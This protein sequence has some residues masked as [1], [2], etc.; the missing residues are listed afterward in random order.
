MANTSKYKGGSKL[1]TFRLPT[2]NYHEVRE[3][4]NELL[5]GYEIG[6]EQA[7]QEAPKL[8]KKASIKPI[9]NKQGTNTYECGCTIDNGLLKRV[10]G[11]KKGKNEH[12]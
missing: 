1:T 12:I 11:C 2:D 6:Q 3:A 5:R 7:K 10:K 4:I 9:V 8:V